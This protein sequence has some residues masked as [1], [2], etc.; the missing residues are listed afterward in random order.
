MKVA[1]FLKNAY[2]KKA[3][4]KAN[5]WG[6]VMVVVLPLAFLALFYFFPLFEIFS[7]SIFPKGRPD[8]SGFT[9]VFFYNSY[10]RVI[11]FTVFQAAISTLLAV[12][13][14]IPGAYMF[15]RF[16]FPGKRILKTIATIPFV[17]PSVVAA[18]ALESILGQ[19][20]LLNSGLKSLFGPD[21][22]GINIEHSL[23]FILIAHVFFNYSVVLRIVGGFWSRLDTSLGESAKMLGASGFRVFFSITLPLLRP[24][25]FAASLLVFIF[26]FS[27]FGIVLILGGP[28]FATIEVEIYRQA[29]HLFNLP[30]A[31]ALSIVQIVFTFIMMW[32]YTWLQRSSA[33]KINPDFTGLGGR[34]PS[35]KIALIFIA[36]NSAAILLFCGGP[37]ISLFVKSFVTQSGLSFEYY[38]ALFVNKSNSIF[39]APP[40]SAI[41][42][43]LMFA[44]GALILALIL[45]LSASYFL[46][47]HR[48]KIAG[49][50]DPIF[51]LPLST[52]AVTLGFGFIIALDQPPL[53]LR[54]SPALVFIAHAIVA[55]PFVVRCLVPA[56]VS[57]PDSLRDAASILGASPA[58]VYRHVDLPI[59]ARAL[60]AGAI[61]AFTISLGE[62]GATLFIARPQTPTIPLAIFRFLGQPGSLN[63][64]QA[65][66]MSTILM[67]VAGFCF[68]VI[69]KFTRHTGMEI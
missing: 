15:A 30:T 19:H 24:A 13:V 51:M 20:G 38:S 25:I 14:G 8:L 59:T 36:V 66:A 10:L 31:A 53:N 41:G 60:V 18:A 43:S 7:V 12:A 44:L 54:S 26:C 29:A 1:F 42:Y 22:S 4:V 28:K 33:V 21:F 49:I 11:V 63:Y 16:D 62:F 6:P 67:L 39:Y 40:I 3:H 37:L 58:N 69:E 57:I 9:K 2:K 23:T 56:M 35:Q 34:K 45:G 47:T 68:L 64:G 61:F 65:M 55:F 50:L 17:L 48:G 52:S 27:S 5:T 46:A 32:V